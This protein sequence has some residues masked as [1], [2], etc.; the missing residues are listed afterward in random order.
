MTRTKRGVVALR[1]LN[2][3]PQPWDLRMKD[4]TVTLTRRNKRLERDKCDYIIQESRLGR[5]GKRQS[6]QDIQLFITLQRAGTFKA[7]LLSA[8]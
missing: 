1:F 2:C 8:T 6:Q 7:R 5:R 4:E 3:Q